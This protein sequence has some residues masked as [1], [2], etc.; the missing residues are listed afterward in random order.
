MICRGTFDAVILLLLPSM[1]ADLAHAKLGEKK[2][3]PESSR[4]RSS[5]GLP[6]PLET[7]RDSYSRAV[8]ALTLSMN[9]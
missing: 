7:A 4:G 3:L 9:D 1:K 6:L 2:A 8:T 5:Y